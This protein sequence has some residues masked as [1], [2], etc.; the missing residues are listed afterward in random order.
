MIL[1]IPISCISCQ[2]NK[3]VVPISKHNDSIHAKIPN[4]TSLIHSDTSLEGKK[5]HIDN[6]VTIDSITHLTPIKSSFLEMKKKFRLSYINIIG[7]NMAL[8]P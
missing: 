2:Q 5:I 7:K 3:R 1:V 8:L 6:T 4:D